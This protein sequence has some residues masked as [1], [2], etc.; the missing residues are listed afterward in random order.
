[1]RNAYSIEGV[2]CQA[3]PAFEQV[4]PSIVMRFQPECFTPRRQARNAK[5]KTM[6]LRGVPGPK[7]PAGAMGFPQKPHE[8][9]VA[10]R[11]PNGDV[12]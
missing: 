1:M 12:G 6:S 2:T 8:D 4:R 5:K 7:D 9:T 3:R 10:G 11:V